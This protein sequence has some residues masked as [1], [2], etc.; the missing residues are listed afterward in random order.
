[1]RHRIDMRNR[2]WLLVLLVPGVVMAA[3]ASGDEPGTKAP[4]KPSQSVSDSTPK[5]KPGKTVKRAAPR[6]PKFARPDRYWRTRMSP[7]QYYVTRR[8]GTEPAFSGIYWDHHEDGIYACIGCGTP[9]FDSEAKFDSGTGWPSYWQVIS[10][11]YLKT[12]PD[13][14]NGTLRTEVNCRVCDA[15]LG[16]V[17]NDGPRPTGLRYCINSASI[18]FVAREDLKDHIDKWREVMGLPPLE[19]E[20]KPEDGKSETD[21]SPAESSDKSE[22]KGNDPAEK[23]SE[24]V[25]KPGL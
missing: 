24:P 23:P 14:S 20:S 16:H 4:D 13:F 21:T 3:S 7:N 6:F 19:P 15:H 25:S 17:F 9:L 18:D 11:N 1:M 5:A 22:T 12:H 2:L 10:R 8:K